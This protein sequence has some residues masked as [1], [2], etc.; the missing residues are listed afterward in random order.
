MTLITILAAMALE[1]F[2]H[3]G[4]SL[5]RFTWFESYLGLMRK[6]L[7]KTGLWKG[8]PGLILILLPILVAVVI[9]YCFLGWML[10][11]LVGLILAIMFLTYSLGPQ[12]LYQDLENYFSAA[13]GEDN[14]ATKKSL[15][16]ILSPMSSDAKASDPKDADAK[17]SDPKDSDAKASDPKD[18]DAKAS[19]PKDSDAKASDP[20][21]SDAKASDKSPVSRSVTKAVLTQFN[22]RVF[23]VIFWFVVLGPFGAVLYRVVA[24][25][26]VSAEKGGSPEASMLSWASYCLDILDWVPIRLAGL[27]YTLVGDFHLGFAYWIKHVISGFDK[28]Q[29]FGEQ[30]GLIALH[31]NEK[32]AEKANPEEN[33]SALALTDR[34][35]ILYLVV[36]ALFVL[37]AWI[38]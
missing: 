9:I 11:G 1:R 34:T 22:R 8:L 38:Y 17:A 23:A 32:N 6:M 16:C 18:A 12:D 15:A 27:G 2:L 4:H 10:Y 29:E 5:F 3:F 35:I 7:A 20:K 36:I 24:K 37:G 28:N 25:T 14:E 13:K 30:S 26:K 33:K 31:L 19:D 21:D